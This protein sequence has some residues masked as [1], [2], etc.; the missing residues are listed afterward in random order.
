M[1]DR[2]K[3]LEV[4]AR[5][6]AAA[7]GEPY[8]DYKTLWQEDAR[9]VLS[10]LQAEGMTVVPVAKGGL[11]E[12]LLGW[13]AEIEKDPAFNP[14]TNAAVVQAFRNGAAE[15]LRLRAAASPAGKEESK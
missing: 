10:H 5:A 9:V 3:T 2:S 14:I 6:L 1:T 7:A 8:I 15:I 4:M 11:T 12:E 13:A